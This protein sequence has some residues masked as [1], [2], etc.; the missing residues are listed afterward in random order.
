MRGAEL[1]PCKLTPE[2]H[3]AGRKSLV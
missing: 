3:F 1:L 2:A